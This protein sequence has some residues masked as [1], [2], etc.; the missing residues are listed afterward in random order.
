[1]KN[2]LLCL[3]FL[4]TLFACR[5]EEDPVF[6]KDVDER[7]NE[8][9]AQYQAVITGAPDGWTA[10]LAT[11][12]GNTYSF[13]FR[14]NDSNRVVMYSDFDTVTSSVP[15]ESSYRL[16]ALQQP[17]LLFD[18]YSY[19]HMLADPDASVN[20]GYYGG[21]LFSDFE[22]MID[23]CTTDSVAL[24]GRFNGSKAVMHKATAQER[25][26]WENKQVYTTVK[27]M[28]YL[29]RILNY[30]K[31]ITYNGTQYELQINKPSKMVVINW[32]DASNTPQAVTTPFYIT[33]TGLQ[34]T[35][36]AVNG[37]NTLNNIVITG[38]NSGTATVQAK[39]NGT[40]APIVGAIAPI[41]PDVSAGQRWWR[42]GYNNQAAYGSYEGFHVNGVDDAFGVTTLHNDTAEYYGLIYYPGIKSTSVFDAFTVYYYMPAG[43][44]IDWLYGTAQSPL[45]LSDGRVVFRT[46]GDLIGGDFPASGPAYDSKQQLLNSSGYWF[47]QTSSTTYD[48][49]GA[50]DAKIW[51]G[52]QQLD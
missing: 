11:T 40:D 5:K 23:T 37:S 15:R 43:D 32:K 38:F 51:I 39:V 31:R 20:G 30:F 21:G 52:W 10:T 36:P 22:F 29:D 26:A 25:A 24:T 50:I 16:K 6:D 35:H 4:I 44:Y 2:I 18:T 33:A 8:T 46:L 12:L 14:F 42:W 49:V 13:Y 1:M 28:S 3:L 17:S 7:L 47:V 19:I 41:N 9:L 34:F 27:G 48:M 45:Y